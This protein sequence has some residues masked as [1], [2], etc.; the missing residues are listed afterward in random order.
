MIESL[1]GPLLSKTPG[2]AVVNIHGIAFEVSIPLS[3]FFYLPEP[4]LSVTLNTYLTLKNDAAQ[5][6]G[7]LSIQEKQAFT[8]LLDV[9][10]VGPKS[11]LAVLSTLRISDLVSAIIDNDITKLSSVPGIGK[12]SAGRLALDLKD[13]VELLITADQRPAIPSQDEDDTLLTDAHSA[14]VNLGYKPAEAKKI[15]TNIRS[16]HHDFQDLINAALKAL[17]K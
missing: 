14:L 8:L 1:T 11:A 17:A 15:L 7:F 5:L 2:C 12:K 13:K 6:Y 4:P 16:D 10:G 9:S 3:T